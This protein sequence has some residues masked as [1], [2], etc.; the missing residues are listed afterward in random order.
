MN[1]L[2]LVFFND[3]PSRVKRY[4]VTPKKWNRVG[5]IL[6]NPTWL[7]PGLH[8]TYV[9]EMC[10]CKYSTSITPY[11]ECIK[12]YKGQVYIRK[13]TV[14][15]ADLGL[16]TDMLVKEPRN[17]IRDYFQ[18]KQDDKLDET[19][20]NPGFVSYVLCKMKYLN[21]HGIKWNTITT[22]DFTPGGK[23][24]KYLLPGLEYGDKLDKI[25]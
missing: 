11:D 12:N 22:K 13:S 9:W 2:D 15:Q 14:N 23:V 21:F 24:E 25:Y 8:G 19:F 7:H 17:T 1:T 10:D 4:L 3:K 6:N 18:F 16:V 20:W 5:I